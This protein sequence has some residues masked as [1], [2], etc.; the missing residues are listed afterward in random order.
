MQFGTYQLSYYATYHQVVSSLYTPCIMYTYSNVL[1]KVTIVSAQ[2][3]LIL[4]ASIYP[5]KFY[6][7][8]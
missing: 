7:S 1:N 4:E 3:G 2:H 5:L 8:M 6:Y